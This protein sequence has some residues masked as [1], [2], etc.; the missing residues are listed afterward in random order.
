ML[1]CPNCMK[2]LQI[3]EVGIPS[4]HVSFAKRF[5]RKSVRY[6]SDLAKKY[7]NHRTVM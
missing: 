6:V 5:G 1:T 4:S 3:I 2:K 7:L